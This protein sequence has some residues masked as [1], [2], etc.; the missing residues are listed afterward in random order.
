MKPGGSRRGFWLGLLALIVLVALGA[1]G[2]F[3]RAVGD[4]QSYAATQVFLSLQDQFNLGVQDLGAGNY[5][6]AKQRFEYIVKEDP[7][8]PGAAEK[9]AEALVKLSFTATPVATETPT[10]TPTPDL[11]NAEVIFSQAQ[12]LVA[13]QD[14]D[15]VVNTL[16]GLRKS[17]PGF[18]T[19]Q[20]DGMYYVALRNRGV[21]KILGQGAYAQSPNLEGGIYDLT[22]AEGFGPLDGQ[23]QGF[24]NFARLYLTGSSFWDLDWTQAEYFFGQVYTQLPNLRDGSGITAT[25]RFRQAAI[26][27]GD[28]YYDKEKYCQAWEHYK[29]AVDMGVDAT[30][31]K[32]ASESYRTCYPPTAEPTA[33]VS[34]EATSEPPTPT[35]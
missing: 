27:V 2:G 3:F 5:D 1:L 25:E 26:K 20:V 17:N 10:L 31:Q 11:R 14:W 7:N 32:K 33:V 13:A 24:R 9:L 19:V 16:E 15:G 35:P 12:Q 4:R 29:P 21:A 18:N 22:L 30:T 8:Y 34:P 6:A 28:L 23:A